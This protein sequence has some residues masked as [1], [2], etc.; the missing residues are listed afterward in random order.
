MK[1]TAILVVCAAFSF[2]SP[3]LANSFLPEEA[4]MKLIVSGLSEGMLD[5]TSTI[6]DSAL[7]AEDPATPGLTWVCGQVRGKNG[8]GGYAQPTPF[9]GSLVDNLGQRLFVVVGIADGSEGSQ[10]AILQTCAGLIK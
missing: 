7:A 1:S 10:F 5:P 8:F 2:C 9:V 4:D 6:V 3:A